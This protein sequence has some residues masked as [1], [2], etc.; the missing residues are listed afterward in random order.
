MWLFLLP[1]VFATFFGLVMGGSSSPAD[2]AAALTVVDLDGSPISEALVSEIEGE[3]VNITRLT[4]EERAVDREIVRA[5]VIPEGF[6]AGVLAGQFTP[7]WPRA[8]FS[9]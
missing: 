7:S 2:I 5:L 9:S 6:G 1:I 4:I 3:G 8:N